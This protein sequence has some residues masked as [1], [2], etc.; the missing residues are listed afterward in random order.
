MR[1]AITLGFPHGGGLPEMLASPAVELEKQ[2]SAFKAAK[3]L[4]V[5][6]KYERIELWLSDEGRSRHAK[7]AKPPPVVKADPPKQK[8]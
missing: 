7:L 1:V 8:T 4:G 6:A 5:N 3:G 2:K